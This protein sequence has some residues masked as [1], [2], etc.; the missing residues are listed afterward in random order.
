MTRETTEIIGKE[1][2]EI[3]ARAFGHCPANIAFILP[4]EVGDT[5]IGEERAPM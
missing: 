1:I 3:V 5:A 2:A 4:H